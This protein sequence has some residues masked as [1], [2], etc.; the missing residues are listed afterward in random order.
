MIGGGGEQKTLRLV[1]KHADLWHSFSDLDTL[2]RKSAILDSH[3]AEIGR[4]AA[5]IQRS[6]GTPDGDP[7]I[8]GEAL[9]KAG[10]S[11]F[12]VGVNGPDYDLSKLKQWIDW[13]NSR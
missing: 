10:A 3:C 7:A 6:V 1:A 9:L 4:D 8:V 2:V 12:T 13:R 5:E 11:L